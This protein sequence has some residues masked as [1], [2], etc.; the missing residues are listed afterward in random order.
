VPPFLQRIMGT[1]P[2]DGSVL[3]LTVD[4]SDPSTMYAGPAMACIDPRA[5]SR[6]ETDWAAV[7]PSPSTFFAEG[8]H[9]QFS[10]FFVVVRY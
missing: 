4:P 7:F 8:L 9:A 2:F 1:T 5:V 3:S 10:Q 6:L